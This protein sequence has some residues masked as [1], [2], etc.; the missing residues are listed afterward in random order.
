MASPSVIV[1]GGGVAGLTAAHE[2]IERG[3]QVD[4]YEAR[5][6]WGGKARSQPVVG[7]GT[8]GRKDLPGEHGFRF[9]PRFYTH[10]IDT[11]SRIPT[12]TGHVVD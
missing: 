9:Y 2:L 10:V 1:I 3:F 11:M 7:T 5:P 12:G 8:G 6:T 4:V